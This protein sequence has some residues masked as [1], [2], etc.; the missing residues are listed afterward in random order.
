MCSPIRKWTVSTLR[1][2]ASNWVLVLFL[3]DFKA[4]ELRSKKLNENETHKES[5]TEKTRRNLNEE[6]S[7]ELE[8]SEQTR[9]NDP[10]SE[11]TSEATNE[12]MNETK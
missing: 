12:Q 2:T 3:C 9:M 6:T 10:T 8:K 11:R 1:R 4:V 5:R 7:N